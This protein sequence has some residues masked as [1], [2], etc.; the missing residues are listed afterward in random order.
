MIEL[1]ISKQSWKLV[2]VHDSAHVAV[3]KKISY[4]YTI[5]VDTGFLID[6]VGTKAVLITKP[7]RTVKLLSESLAQKGKS[8]LMKE[9]SYQ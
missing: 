6:W 3:I 4:K 1:K 8:N 5:M 9:C 7:D 2:G